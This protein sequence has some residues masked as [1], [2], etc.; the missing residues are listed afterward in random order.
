MFF[1]EFKQYQ[2]LKVKGFAVDFVASLPGYHA[3][4]KSMKKQ[5]VKTVE[6]WTSLAEKLG[7][8]QNTMTL[9]VLKS[10]SRFSE[11]ASR[12]T[13]VG[14]FQ[15]ET[16]KWFIKILPICSTNT[17]NLPTHWDRKTPHQTN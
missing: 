9:K 2:A 7:G 15:D 17:S 4:K 1:D 13:P 3:H 6:F 14:V 5:N 12:N 16:L 8:K 10:L 11:M